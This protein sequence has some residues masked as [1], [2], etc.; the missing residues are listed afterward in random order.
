MW[1][2]T[3]LPPRSSMQCAVGAL[4]QL[5]CI[6]LHAIIWCQAVAETA[7]INH[8]TS[9][10]HCIRVRACVC[11]CVCVC[12]SVCVFVCICGWVREYICVWVCVCACVCVRGLVCFTSRQLCL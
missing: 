9:P 12:V 11:V 6:K 4:W 7:G 2:G 10:L 8:S 1:T 5:A 3:S